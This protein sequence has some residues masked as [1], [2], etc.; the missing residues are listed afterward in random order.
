[1]CN[2]IK[3]SNIKTNESWIVFGNK[4]KK[5]DIKLIEIN[6]NR[7][8]FLSN[9]ESHNIKISNS[10]DKKIWKFNFTNFL[11]LNANQITQ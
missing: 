1:M 11:S 3:T 9:N 8:Q 5:N 10:T 2:S 7:I 4:Y 6:T